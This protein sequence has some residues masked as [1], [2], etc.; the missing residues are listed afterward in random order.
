MLFK[1]IL[2][3]S[4]FVFIFNMTASHAD[5]RGN[6]DIRTETSAKLF[7]G[8]ES[9]SIDTNL[10]YDN[11]DEDYEFSG[12]RLKI[13]GEFS[14]GALVGL[15]LLSG[16]TDEVIDP[17]GDPFELKTD[18]AV[19]LFLHLGRPFY[20]RLAWSFWDTE[21]T[22][23]TTNVTEKEE[24]SAFEYGVGYQLWLGSNLSVYADYSRKTGDARY[25]AHFSGDGTVDYDSEQV[26]VGIGMTF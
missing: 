9:V 24:V 11:G 25:P 3:A 8:V 12:A 6:T 4:I 23:L 2:T 1:N 26:S 13:A 19:G 21:Y 15:E 10:D 22:D 5:I 20:F 14:E 18:T 7:L 16:D 17:F